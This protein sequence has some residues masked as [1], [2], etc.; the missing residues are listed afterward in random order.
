MHQRCAKETVASNGKAG[1]RISPIG[2]RWQGFVLVVL[3]AVTGCLPYSCQREAPRDL[4]PAD[5]LSRQLAEATPA[6]TLRSVWQATGPEGQALAFPRTVLFGPGETVYASDVER[7]SVF[8]FDAGDGAFLREVRD[9]PFEAPY[10]VGRQGDT[11]DV[12][13][14]FALRLDRVVGTA[15]VDSL[16]LP[17]EL[18]GEGPMVWGAADDGSVYV[19]LLASDGRPGR[20][21]QVDRAS[22]TVAARR[23]LEGALWRRAGM[24]R[25]WGDTLLSLSGFRPVADVYPRDLA[26]APTDTLALV[27]FD[28]PM[29][30]RSRSYLLGDA[31]QPPLLTESAA[32]AGD[33]LFVINMRPGWLQVDVYGRDGRLQ[34]RLVTGPPQLNEN[35]YPRDLAVRRRADGGYDLAVAFTDPRPMVELFRWIPVR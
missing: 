31:G 33:R 12:L 11:L 7:N 9:V 23:P 21:V 13:S 32:V 16:A 22:G 27:G 19:K 20:V 18:P 17:V 4:F 5:S 34:D 10:L 29:L 26:A 1:R 8:A 28:S 2:R 15:R 25:L 24:L 14:P 30:A 6:D 3:F 35:Y